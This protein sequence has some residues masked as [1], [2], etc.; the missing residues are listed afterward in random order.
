[1]GLMIANIGKALLVS[2]VQPQGGRGAGVLQCIL[3]VGEVPA[4]VPGVAQT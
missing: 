4:H 2:S 3:D 1:M